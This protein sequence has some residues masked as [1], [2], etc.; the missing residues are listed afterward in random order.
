MRQKKEKFVE[1]L[2]K[3]WYNISVIYVKW[4]GFTL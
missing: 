3:E 1:Q 2:T 4:K